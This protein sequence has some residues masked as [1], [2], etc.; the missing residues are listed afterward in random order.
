MYTVYASIIG[1]LLEQA[2]MFV[3]KDYPKSTNVALPIRAFSSLNVRFKTLL[4][5]D[6]FILVQQLSNLRAS[7]SF[8][9]A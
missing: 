7:I 1:E 4:I 8:F 5:T 9:L 2:K 6:R 3:L